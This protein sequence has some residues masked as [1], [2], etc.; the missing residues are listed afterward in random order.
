MNNREKMLESVESVGYNIVTVIC[1]LLL[2]SF[3]SHGS[4]EDEKGG[5]RLREIL[6][7]P[8]CAFPRL[9]DH[10][11]TDP[12]RRKPKSVPDCHAVEKWAGLLS[13]MNHPRNRG[14]PG[15]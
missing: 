13:D 14:D 6:N 1:P 2:P 7:L 4:C 3:V 10:R 5:T 12:G 8:A 15:G 9:Q 11:R